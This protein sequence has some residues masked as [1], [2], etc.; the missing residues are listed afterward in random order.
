MRCSKA[1]HWLSRRLDGV[2]DERAEASLADHMAVCA[3][4]RAYADGLGV[5]DVDLLDAPDP[6]VDFAARV[7][8]CLEERPAQRR[9]VLSR[10][11]LFRP[12]AAGLGVAASFAGFVVG[13]F[14]EHANGES[15]VV[16]AQPVEVVAG[17]AIDPL[18][19]DSVES[20]LVA[21]LSN[22]EE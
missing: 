8:E 7:M 20:V 19:E 1:Q 2:L 16:N 14:L 10:P 13:S 5:L 12:V 3:E 4:C 21:M 9:A 18:A 6:T 17:D 11:G 15:A 22:T